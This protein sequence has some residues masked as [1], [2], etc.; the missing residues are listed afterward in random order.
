MGDPA[1]ETA[2]LMEQ[3]EEVEWERE[4]RSGGSGPPPLRDLLHRLPPDG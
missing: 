3:L 1:E 4:K 2:A